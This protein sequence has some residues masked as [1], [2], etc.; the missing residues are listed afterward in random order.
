MVHGDAAAAVVGRQQVA[1]LAVGNGMRWN[2][3]IGVD[4]AEQRDLPR[5]LVEAKAGQ[6]RRLDVRVVEDI[7]R[8]V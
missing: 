8:W 7:E 4:A 1:P 3:D 5:C 6:R 2:T